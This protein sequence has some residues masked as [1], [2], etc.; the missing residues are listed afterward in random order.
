MNRGLVKEPLYCTVKNLLLEEIRAGRFQKLLPTEHELCDLYSVSRATIR[1][2]LQELKNENIIRTV[3]GRG[4]FINASGQQLKMRIDK[5]KGFYQLIQESGR[6]PS[7]EELT[8]TELSLFDIDYDLPDVFFTEC[9]VLIERLVKGDDMPAIY[10]KEYVP[11]RYI[12]VDAD[13]N[14]LP[15]SIYEM[16]PAI[17]REHIQYTISEIMPTLSDKTVAHLFHIKRDVPLIQVK[18]RHFNI[19]D[20]VIVYSEVFVNSSNAIR[21]NVLRCD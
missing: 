21:F 12:L 15:P 13:M 4:T 17:T 7:V 3:H 9:V 16:T 14:Y 6:T 5:F 10:L 11:K 19:N 20:A 18:E 1:S 2:A 8:R